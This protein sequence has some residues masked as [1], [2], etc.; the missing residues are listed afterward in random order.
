MTSTTYQLN[1]FDYSQ[2]YLVR[3]RESIG[4]RYT[5]T[6]THASKRSLLNALVTLQSL[7]PRFY[8]LR[9]RSCRS[10]SVQF[11]VICESERTTPLS[12]RIQCCSD[13]ASSAPRGQSDVS[14]ADA[15]FGI[16]RGGSARPVSRYDGGG[17]C[18][19]RARTTGLRARCSHEDQSAEIKETSERTGRG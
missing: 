3:G 7:S 9:C 4:V 15:R 18:D 5:H 8:I 16:A 14:A 12:R 2:L 6:H 1:Y 10:S 13:R 11:V 17:N 19:G